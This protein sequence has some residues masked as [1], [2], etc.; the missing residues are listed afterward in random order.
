[1]AGQQDNQNVV[2]WVRKGWG[3]PMLAQALM[4][5]DVMHGMHL[6]IWS[7]IQ[8][9]HTSQN[10]LADLLSRSFTSDGVD[11]INVL[12]EFFK[13]ARMCHEQCAEVK[14]SETLIN[15][16]FSLEPASSNIED[17]MD[18]VN[19]ASRFKLAETVRSAVQSMERESN[20]AT[21][22]GPCEK[23]L[24]RKWVSPLD[25]VSVF[26]EHWDEIGLGGYQTLQSKTHGGKGKG[27]NTHSVFKDSV[28]FEIE[29]LLNKRVN[30]RNGATE[31]KVKWKQFSHV[32]NTWKA[33]E[34]LDQAPE[35][36]AA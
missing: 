17:L 22:G 12:S 35:A 5:R 18:E 36:V 9:I 1:V 24:Q 20:K 21:D 27:S 11:D 3:K 30:P 6:D 10:V 14:I 29:C 7:I 26:N 19:D 8:Y 33:L 28:E 32:Y 2:D 25:E 34:E 13:A 31:Y 23:T 4:R 15:K 16:L